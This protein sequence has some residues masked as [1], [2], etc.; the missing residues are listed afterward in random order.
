MSRT[1]RLF[2]LLITLNTKYRFTAQELANEFSVSKRTILRDLQLLSE[3]GVPLF[4]SP[5]PNGGY[6]LIKKQKLPTISLTPEEATG[7]LL[8]YQL[9]EDGPFQQEN[10]STLT[11]IRSNMSIEMLQKIEALQDRLA[12]DSPKRSF[13]NH[14]LKELF[15]A[16]LDKKHLQIEYESRSGYS[17]RTIF[18]HGI[19]LANGL[20]YSPAFCYK[21]KR[22]VPFRVD[23]I[24]SLKIQQ[25][26]S[27][28]LPID[29]TIQQWL[30]QTEA[31]SKELTLRA[32]LTKKGCKILDPHPIGEWI[33]VTS[34]G[35]GII[36]E[37]F[38]ESDIPFIGGL[39]LS[40]G[41][42]ILIK[43]PAELIQFVREKALEVVSQYSKI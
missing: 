42:E 12:I 3:M 41:A 28:P 9:L 1:G 10:I 21:R 35:T 5:G 34:N 33:Q 26:F 15:Q 37:K 19:V 30:N 4:S 27:E 25:D 13:K 43:E 8:S 16:S 2:E 39:F 22:N 11:K 6:T 17:T 7:L 36:E 32:T 38:R 29:M 20:W 18:P 23:R 40:L 24:L 31:A 14:Y